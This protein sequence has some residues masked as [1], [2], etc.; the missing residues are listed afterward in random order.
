[1][2]GVNNRMISYQS[3]THSNNQSEED[4]LISEGDAYSIKYEYHKAMTAYLTA[5]DAH[6]KKALQKCYALV[7]EELG[8]GMIVHACRDAA[9]KRSPT[10]LLMLGEMFEHGY[11]VEKNCIEAAKN[12]SAAAELRQ[13]LAG[14][15]LLK[16]YATS[17][18]LDDD[19]DTAMQCIDIA[20]V[21]NP[22]LKLEFATH[23]NNAAL[24][25]LYADDNREV[26]G[27]KLVQ[28]YSKA[29][30]LGSVKALRNLGGMYEI[31]RGVDKDKVKA[32]EIYACAAEKE[33]AE[34]AYR[35][36]KDARKVDNSVQI[37][38][39]YR[40]N[41]LGPDDFFKSPQTPKKLRRY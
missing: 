40:L 22:Y 13:F 26:I 36:R 12:Y 35:T 17:T 34:P 2:Q 8:L 11:C 16:M 37:D 30:D 19:F 7:K 32:K 18:V 31:G 24:N 29:S 3:L 38:P 1:M 41:S 6:S 27:L 25:Y 21:E 28:I 15:K 9:A 14:Q 4:K 20:V 39:A 10:A 5:A 33:N 23:L